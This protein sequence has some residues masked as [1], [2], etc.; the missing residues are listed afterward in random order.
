MAVFFL[1]PRLTRTCWSRAWWNW[2]WSRISS[3]CALLLVARL[4]SMIMLILARIVCFTSFLRVLNY[5]FCRAACQHTWPRVFFRRRKWS[6]SCCA[7]L[8]AHLIVHL[9]YILPYIFL[10]NLDLLQILPRTFHFERYD[11]S[12]C[13]SGWPSCRVPCWAFSAVNVENCA[14]ILQLFFPWILLLL[15][16][17][18][19]SEI[20]LHENL[21]K[22]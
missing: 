10:L 7:N 17:S 2:R 19:S 4:L 14:A 13:V 6:Q 3:R 12:W 9:P 16:A 1:G 20:Y 5:V 11:L 18:V 8:A 22:F 15:S 21:V